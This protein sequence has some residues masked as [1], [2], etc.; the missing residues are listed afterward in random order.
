MRLQIGGALSKHI[1]ILM[2]ARKQKQM[3][4]IKLKNKQA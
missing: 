4:A 1:K 3:D 2:N